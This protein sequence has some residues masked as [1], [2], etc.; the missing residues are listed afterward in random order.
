MIRVTVWRM[1]RCT[2][3]GELRL[4]VFFYGHMN[5]GERT[6]ASGG[7]YIYTMKKSRYSGTMPRLAQYS[8]LY[9]ASSSSPASILRRA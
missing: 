7:D 5:A 9:E 1:K 6:E 8:L 4:S 2:Y 3:G